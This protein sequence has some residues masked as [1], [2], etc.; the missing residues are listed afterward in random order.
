MLARHYIRKNEKGIS[1]IEVLVSIVILSVGLLGIAGLQAAVLKYQIGTQSR[2]ALAGLY[3]D[4]ADRIRINSDVAGNNFITG[5]NAVSQYAL[6][7]N[8]AT[9]QADALATP[10][11]NCISASCTTAERATFDMVAWRQLIRASVPQGAALISGNKSA[12]FNIT[13]MWFDKEFTDK[14]NAADSVLI[15]APTCTGNESGLA[16]QQCCP[17]A[18]AAP[19]GVRCARFSFIP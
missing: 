10:N 2:A 5:V 1:L 7:S 9:Q 12:G 4:I 14:G 18:A 8:W 17:A 19:A 6:A 3:S 11:P 13:L 16:Q 15:S